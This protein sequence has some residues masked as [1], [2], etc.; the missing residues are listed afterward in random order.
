MIE[1][2]KTS[3]L[4]CRAPALAKGDVLFWNALTVHGSLPTTQPEHSRRSFTAHFIPKSQK[5]LQYQKRVSDPVYD[6]VDGALISRPKD[7][8][9]FLNRLVLFVESR[10]PG[11]FQ[12]AKKTAIKFVMAREA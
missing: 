8:A 10:F 5:F 11:P 1:T 7:Q 2:I 6:D 3:N 12:L 9:K 4:E